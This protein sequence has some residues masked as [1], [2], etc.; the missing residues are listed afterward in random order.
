M[1]QRCLQTIQLPDFK[2]ICQMSF[3]N[4]LFGYQT[5]IDHSDTG[6]VRSPNAYYTY[7]KTDFFK[8]KFCQSKSPKFTNYLLLLVT[9]F[10]TTNFRVSDS[11]T[12]HKATWLK[13]S[14]PCRKYSVEVSMATCS[15][16]SAPV[17]APT[18]SKLEV[19]ACKDMVTLVKAPTTLPLRTTCHNASMTLQ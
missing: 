14:I 16:D 5:C 18:C 7:R 2:S 17:P 10:L 6:H 1:V 12:F 13:D 3:S 15:K 8:I 9:L 4:K 11:P 19:T